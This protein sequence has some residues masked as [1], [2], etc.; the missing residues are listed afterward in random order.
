MESYNSGLLCLVFSLGMFQG[1]AMCQNFT[2]FD[3]P[4]CGQTTV[5]LSIHRLLEGYLDCYNLLATDNS[6]VNIHVCVSV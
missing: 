4:L 5:C 3:T 1:S 2:P 6:A